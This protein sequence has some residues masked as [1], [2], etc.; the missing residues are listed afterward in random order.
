M[1]P[2]LA[3]RLRGRVCGAERSSEE[4]GCAD[5]GRVHR[6]RLPPTVLRMR[7]ALSALR[8]RYAMRGT[9]AA[10]IRCAIGYAVPGMAIRNG[11]AL[12]RAAPTHLL[13]SARY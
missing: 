8:M 9:E 1:A 2:F 11:Y 6:G 4:A 12:P 13:C 10:C 3:T 7:Y 5:P